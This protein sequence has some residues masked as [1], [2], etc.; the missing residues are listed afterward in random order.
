MIGGP[1][2]PALKTAGKMET[3]GKFTLSLRGGGDIFAEK[4]I[5]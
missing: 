4:S 2:S 5:S 1:F 3:K